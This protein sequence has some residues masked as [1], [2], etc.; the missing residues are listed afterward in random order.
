MHIL[1]LLRCL[2]RQLDA[3]KTVT[4][5]ALRKHLKS[6]N[7]LHPLFHIKY[8]PS[9]RIEDSVIRRAMEICGHV[10]WGKVERTGKCMCNM[11]EEKVDQRKWRLRV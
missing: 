4:V 7:R 11:S 6:S 5:P 10:Q 8:L 1:E 9:C 3:G 2:Y